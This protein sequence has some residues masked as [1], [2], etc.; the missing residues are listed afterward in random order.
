MANKTI[1][2]DATCEGILKDMRK[3]DP[4]FSFSLWVRRKMLEE[5][6][7]DHPN[8][9]S[10]ERLVPSHYYCP[11]CKAQGEHWSTHCPYSVGE[12]E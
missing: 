10:F 1:S 5:Y 6:N 2:I 7:Q 9:K 4:F 8:L 3:K 11:I 12:E